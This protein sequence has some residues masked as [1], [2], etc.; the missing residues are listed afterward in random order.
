V[1][2]ACATGMDTP[3]SSVA[4]SWSVPG[5][6][7]AE[8]ESV[9]SG[10]TREDRAMQRQ[11]DEEVRRLVQNIFDCRT[12]MGHLLVGHPDVSRALDGH[13]RELQLH[14]D[15][16]L[17]HHTRLSEAH[18]Q[19]VERIRAEYKALADAQKEEHR[20]V[21]RRMAAEH[22]ET[23]AQL[24][25]ATKG[26]AGRLREE[27]QRSLRTI[28]EERVRREEEKQASEREWGERVEMLADVAER[29]K[30]RALEDLRAEL[31]GRF[32]A[33]VDEAVQRES[34]S[35]ERVR[36]ERDQQ[37]C[38]LIRDLRTQLRETQG[39]L[40]ADRGALQEALRLQGEDREL[41]KRSGK[42]VARLEAGLGEAAGRLEEALG[43]ARALRARAEGLEGERR[44]RAAAEELVER[45]R[46]A[47]RDLTAMQDAHTNELRDI[48]ID[49]KGRLS[50]KRGEIDGMATTNTAAAAELERNAADL[51]QR[52]QARVPR[53]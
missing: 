33:E 10:A 40:E 47:F 53:Y 24:Q 51:K 9:V 42:E 23:K 21:V 14:I 30:Q 32:R 17:L 45:Q 4:S 27:Q 11:Q 52:R 37:A 12:S 1:D 39:E 38:A 16:L 25:E 46:Q 31:E 28:Q 36:G 50:A 49:M 15:R 5:L 2:G 7:G 3:L 29:G 26:W 8:S 22:E 35:K 6:R 44:E 41:L 19:H 48:N 18:A 34:E 13:V 43:A 20:S